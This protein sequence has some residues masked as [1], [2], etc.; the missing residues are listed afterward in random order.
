MKLY[1][2]YGYFDDHPDLGGNH[3]IF[4]NQ[5]WSIL[6]P[7]S[8]SICSS[9]SS[10]ASSLF[11]CDHHSRRQFLSAVVRKMNGDVMIVLLFL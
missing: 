7:D 2:S 3:V 11:Y 9:S 6:G 8:E 10:E 5:L 1:Y 4:V